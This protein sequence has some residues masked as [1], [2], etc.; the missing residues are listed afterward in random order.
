L[1]GA[2]NFAMQNLAGTYLINMEG[3][4]EEEKRYRTDK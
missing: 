1:I 2:S 4:K 3:L